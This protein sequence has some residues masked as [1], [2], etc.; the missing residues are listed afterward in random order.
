LDKTIWS[1]IKLDSYSSLD[2]DI[3]C[4]VL[5]IGGGIAGILIAYK[6]TNAGK[7]VVVVEMGKIGEKKTVKTTASITLLQDVSYHELISNIGFDKT[8][9]YYKACQDAILEYKKLSNYLD[10]YYEDVS[11]YKYF[12]DDNDNLNKEIEALNNLEIAYNLVDKVSLPILFDKAI[13]F[14]N[15]GQMNPMMLL[16][17]LSKFIKI[18]ENTK[19][20]KVKD[21]KAYTESYTIT[22]DSIVVATGFPFNK[23]RGLYSLK[24]HQNK[25]YVITTK[26]TLNFKGNVVGSKISDLYFRDYNGSLI[27]GGNDIKTGKFNNGFTD[28]FDFVDKNIDEKVEYRWINQ[29]CITL[30]DIPYI[31]RLGLIKDNIYVATGFN[32][33][34]MTGA[35]I[36]STVIKSLICDDVILYENIFS[37]SRL[38][39]IAPLIDNVF[40]ST[41][42]LLKFNKKR[43]NH[44]GC[45]LIF[46]DDEK[47]YECPCHGSKFDSNGKLIDGPSINDLDIKEN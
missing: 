16:K 15:Q 9:T 3:K 27:I 11:S 18:Y 21:N 4:D 45:S 13:E 12:K 22:A 5:V 17:E 28:L 20:I 35:M 10:F 39:K 25:S 32:L 2:S 26:N 23:F 1:N 41:I 31:G 42:N 46:D 7:N 44:L 6:L 40:T 47:H 24:M 29:D 43:C 34:G 14:K 37:P 33:W 36:A 30:D 38:Y 8:K 19:I